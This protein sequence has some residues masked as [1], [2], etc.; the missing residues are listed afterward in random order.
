MI[1][2]R[3]VFKTDISTTPKYFRSTHRL[4]I[5]RGFRAC[6]YLR[7]DIARAHLARASGND[8]GCSRGDGIEFAQKVEGLAVGF[9]R[10]G[11]LWCFA[12]CWVVL[13]CECR[14]GKDEEEECVV[15]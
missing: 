6:P 8:V 2:E 11:V 15:S 4:G 9:A 3:N 10:E 7:P 14:Q 13:R 5:L 12:L 1:R